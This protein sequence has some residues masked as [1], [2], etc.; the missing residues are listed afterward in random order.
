VI[1]ELTPTQLAKAVA[2]TNR[3]KSSS[4]LLVISH[5]ALNAKAARTALERNIFLANC[6]MVLAFRRPVSLQQVQRQLGPR[7]PF[8]AERS[9]RLNVQWSAI[10][11]GA[12][13]Q[14]A[15]LRG[16]ILQGAHLQ[17]IDLQRANLRGADLRGAFLEGAD[18]QVLSCEAP[19]SELLMRAVQA[20]RDCLPASCSGRAIKYG[21]VRLPVRWDAVRYGGMNFALA[22]SMARYEK[23]GSTA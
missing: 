19:T 7:V 4:N 16:A 5:V 3:A 20:L 18:L 22:C 17:D 10:L 2:N 15:I 14:G 6:C 9:I 1:P 13:L 8:C 23:A 11:H 21:C 12:D